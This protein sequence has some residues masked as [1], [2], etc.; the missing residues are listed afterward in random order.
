MTEPAVELIHRTVVAAT[1]GDE[2]ASSELLPL[3]Y[4]ELRRLA[5]SL[6]ARRGQGQTLQPTALVHE[7]YLRVAGREHGSWEGRKHFFGAAARA[8][9]DILV[10]EARRKGAIKRGG[11]RR[12]V[13]LEGTALE[14][15]ALALEPPRED[16]IELDQALCEL[17]RHDARK[18]RIVM[19]R[20]FAGLS[21]AET[22]A[23]LDVSVATV[24]REWRYSRAWLLRRFDA[25]NGREDAARDVEPI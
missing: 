5:R 25:G 16:M 13:G 18:A 15:A 14:G 9:R 21:L 22:A 6:M 23:V 3:L 10:E 12:R 11:G 7:A 4:D 1:Q 19:L 17:E 2:R 8:M 24:D 20:Y